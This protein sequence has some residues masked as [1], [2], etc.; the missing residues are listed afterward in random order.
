MHQ[1][2]IVVIIL[3]GDLERLVDR[4]GVFLHNLLHVFLLEL[5]GV[6]LVPRKEG[7]WQRYDWYI[8]V[9]PSK[10]DFAVLYLLRLFKRFDGGK[11]AVREGR[12]STESSFI[13]LYLPFLENG[14]G[15]DFV[16]VEFLQEVIE[17]CEAVFC[18]VAVIISSRR[19][20]FAAGDDQNVKFLFHM[21]FPLCDHYL[22]SDAHNIDTFF[23]KDTP[24]LQIFEFF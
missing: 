22:R 14:E 8:L 4:N 3:F 5:H 20:V 18:E 12:G 10:D 9:A 13:I 1:P 7:Y 16:G 2:W 24:F 15:F 11:G 19:A 23:E 17:D 21:F 6:H